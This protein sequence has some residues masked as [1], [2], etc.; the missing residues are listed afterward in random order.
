MGLTCSINSESYADGNLA[1]GRDYRARYIKGDNPNNNGYSGFGVWGVSVGLK[2]PPHGKY[3]LLTS[4]YNWRRSQ[5]PSSIVMPEEKEEEE[6]EEEDISY[7]KSVESTHL[8]Y[9][10]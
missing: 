3:V 4:S 10:I 5:G 9:I 1:T 2:T 8:S 7:S 6:G